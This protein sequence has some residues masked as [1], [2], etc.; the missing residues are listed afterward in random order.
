VTV[1]TSTQGTVSIAMVIQCSKSEDFSHFEDILGGTSN[2]NG[3][4]DHNHAPF[5]GDFSL[6]GM[7]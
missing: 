2:L 3:S 1:T 4:C 5:G 6:V 7:T